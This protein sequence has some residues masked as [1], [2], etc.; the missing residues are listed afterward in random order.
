[1]QYTRPGQV[2]KKAF[3]WSYSKLKN[4]RTCPKRF[5]EIDILKNYQDDGADDPQGALATGNR[6]H[7]AFELRVAKGTPLPAEFAE[8]EEAMLRVLKLPGKI[9]VEQQLAIREDLTPCEWFAKDAWFRCKADVL[10][11]NG[12]VACALDYKFG[13]ILEEPEQ[14]A[15]MAQAVFAHCPEVQAVRTEYW[16]MRDDAATREN[17]FRKKSTEVWAAVMP[18]VM[19][20][21]HAH[22]TMDYPPTPNGLCKKYCKVVSCPYHGKGGGNR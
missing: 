1:M 15:L 11:I 7:K 13:K 8:F 16:W 18:Q 17:F 22:D 2:F 14:L 9:L 19:S 6:G 21:K 10:A 3:S 20:L 12:P 5:Y 4:F